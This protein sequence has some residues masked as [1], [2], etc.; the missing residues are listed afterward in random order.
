VDTKIPRFLQLIEITK[1]KSSFLFGPRST[2]KTFTIM[3]QLGD[4][5]YINL[6]RA[7]ER[8]RYLS[9]PSLL[10]DTVKTMNPDFPIVI[11]EVQLAPEL[12]YEVH[13]IIESTQYRFLLTGSSAR[14]LKKTNADMLGGR[15]KKAEFFP[16]TWKELQS[17]DFFDLNKYLLYGGLPNVYFNDSPRDELSDYFDTYLNLEIKAESEVRNL[18]GFE[19]FCERVALLSGQ[20]LVISSLASDCQISAPTVRGYLEILEDTLLGFQ[21]RPWSGVRRKAISSSKFYLFDLGILWFLAGVESIPRQSDLYGRAFE[22]FIVN[23]VR[24][25]I[26]YKRTNE[27]LYFW[28]TTHKDEVDLLI[29]DRMAVEIKAKSK[30]TDRDAG[31]L[32]KLAEEGFKGELIVVSQDQL[33]RVSGDKIQF[34]YWETF[35][36]KLWKS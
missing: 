21:L 9:N 29:G 34:L 19:N 14:K 1:K 36:E 2:G 6:L 18:A 25:C 16:L 33:N 13:H 8:R 27:T 31:S 7:A 5:Q 4:K 24:A 10:Q 12:L 11:D 17:T 20:T 28:R 30:T 35:L 26:S 3:D 15:A 32:L 23:E 22:H